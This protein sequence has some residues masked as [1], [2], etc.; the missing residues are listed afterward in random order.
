MEK[1]RNRKG[2]IAVVAIV[3]ALTASVGL[4]VAYF[5]DY[6]T[7][8]GEV[9]LNLSGETQITEEVTDTQKVIK[10]V[11]TG[12]EGDADV[13]VRLSV[14]GPDGMKVRVDDEHWSKAK[15]SDWYY[16]DK[17][18]AP[19]ETTGSITASIED[20]PVDTDLSKFDII[21]NHESAI[22]VYDENNTV[23]KPEGW[24]YIPTIRTK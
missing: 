16:Y 2:I 22:A 21:V 17:V 23:K 6:E 20:L 18:L 11:N 19:G 9:S 10:V 1:R 12:S 8:M 4:T 15:D 24:D 3:L 5:S 7:A 13:V 14:Y